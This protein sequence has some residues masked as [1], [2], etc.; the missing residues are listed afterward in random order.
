[1]LDAMETN[2]IYQISYFNKKNNIQ[3][4]SSTF[5]FTNI[6]DSISTA[7]N[8]DYNTEGENS[9]PLLDSNEAY[10]ID[11]KFGNII[12]NTQLVDLIKSESNIML[13]ES[14]VFPYLALKDLEK[15][16]SYMIKEPQQC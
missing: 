10:Y 11:L 2:N 15:I 16:C 9:V 14:L 1:M 8:E 13:R 3:Q 6:N 7:N 4:S 12:R 5:S